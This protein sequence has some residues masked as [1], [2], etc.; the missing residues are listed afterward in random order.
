MT[1]AA[2]GS[3]ADGLHDDPVAFDVTSS[4]TVFHGAIWD[5]KRETFAYGDAEITREYV[6]HTGAVAVLAIDDADRV[7][8]I[9]QYRHPVRMREWEIP[10]GLLDVTDEPPLAAV[11]RELVEEADLVAAEWSVLAEYCTTPGGSDEAIRVYLARGLT[12]TAEAF[13]RT[14]EEAD[15]ETRWVDLD[16]VVTAV[17]ERRIQNPSTVIA[18]LQAHVARSRGWTT[19]GP[20]DAPWPR[21]PKLRDGGGASGS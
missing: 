15:I 2:A 20:A 21:H 14:D 3:P 16:E 19:L 4:E 5:V 17:L 13:A 1:D 11:Q 18:V 10:A 9:K 6:D 12:P 8:L 7:L